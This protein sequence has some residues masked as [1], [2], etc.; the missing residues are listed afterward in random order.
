MIWRWR[1]TCENGFSSQKNVIF[2]AFIFLSKT[3][4]KY[5]FFSDLQFMT[6]LNLFWKIRQ[7]IHLRMT[8]KKCSL[9]SSKTFS[10]PFQSENI[11]IQCDF[12]LYFLT[13]DSSFVL[14]NAQIVEYPIVY[15]NEAFC[16]MSGYSR[17]DVMQKTCR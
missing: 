8:F 10:Y 11:F 13:A 4:K 5:F 15:C 2:C 14:A 1:K 6:M 3:F 17:A 12:F 7:R 16:K 9:F